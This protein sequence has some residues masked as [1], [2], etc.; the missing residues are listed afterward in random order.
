[1]SSIDSVQTFLAFFDR[2]SPT[3][4]RIAVK[5]LGER[6]KRDLEQAEGAT[7]EE[8]E[9]N[10]LSDELFQMYDREEKANGSAESMSW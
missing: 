8:D 2:L 9:L 4:K 3:E 1:M 6:V 10:F 5:E 7:L